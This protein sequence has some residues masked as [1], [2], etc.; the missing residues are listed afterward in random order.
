M[1]NIEMAPLENREGSSCAQA[2]MSACVPYACAITTAPMVVK[3]ANSL[4]LVAIFGVVQMVV[5]FVL[6]HLGFL[7]IKS[8]LKKSIPQSGKNKKSVKL[9]SDQQQ[10]AGKAKYGMLLSCYL[11]ATLV[12]TL[13]VSSSDPI[14]ASGIALYNLLFICAQPFFR[15]LTYSCTGTCSPWVFRSCDL[16][17]LESGKG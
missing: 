2:A 13:L 3:R 4:L 7:C 12:A 8:L 9:S 10:K 17:M 6:S 1:C 14:R 15:A 11:V 16:W 5:F